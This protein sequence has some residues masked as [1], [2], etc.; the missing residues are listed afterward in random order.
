MIQIQPKNRRERLQ[1]DK[2]YL[3]IK[4]KKFNITLIGKGI[5]LTFS[6]I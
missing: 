3:S 4:K 1:P 2:G 5:I 6:F